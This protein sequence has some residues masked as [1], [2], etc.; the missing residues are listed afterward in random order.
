MGGVIQ[1]LWIATIKM[2]ETIKL[3]KKSGA[4]SCRRRIPAAVAGKPAMKEIQP[5]K[6]GH[7]ERRRGERTNFVG[8]E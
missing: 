8:V 2:L 4:G 6:L 7:L 1:E 3:S 5:T